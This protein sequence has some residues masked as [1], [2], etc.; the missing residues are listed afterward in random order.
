MIGLG[1]FLSE[2]AFARIGIPA[3]LSIY[4]DIF[5][6]CLQ[7]FIFCTLT[8]MNIYMA[9]EDSNEAIADIKARKAEK[10]ARKAAKKAARQAAKQ[11]KNGQ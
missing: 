2:F 11:A 5:S 3:I 7:A 8:M 4:F 1:G 9:Y 6:G 10:A